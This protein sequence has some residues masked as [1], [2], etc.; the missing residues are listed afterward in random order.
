MIHIS[1]AGQCGVVSGVLKFGGCCCICFY[2]FFVF[3]TLNPSG[4]P[5]TALNF[6]LGGWLDIYF[7]FEVHTEYPLSTPPHY[8]ANVEL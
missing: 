4:L 3:L 1:L 7:T 5:F 8:N 2:T 6:C